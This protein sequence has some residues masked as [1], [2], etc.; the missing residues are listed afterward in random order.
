MTL[1]GRVFRD[2]TPH[3]FETLGAVV[4]DELRAAFRKH[5]A[6]GDIAWL[7]IDADGHIRPD[8]AWQAKRD[9]EHLIEARKGDWCDCPLHDPRP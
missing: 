8:P 4:N 5:V 1:R 7:H 2:P 3:P 9:E 6:A